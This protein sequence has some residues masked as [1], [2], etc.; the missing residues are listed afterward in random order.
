MSMIVFDELID[1]FRKLLR[2]YLH[3]MGVFFDFLCSNF[4]DLMELEKR[5]VLLSKENKKILEMQTKLFDLNPRDKQLSFLS[6]IYLTLLDFDDRKISDLIKKSKRLPYR[7][8]LDS[9]LKIKIPFV[10][11]SCVIYASFNTIDG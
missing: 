2:N 8:L 9:E 1:S 10:K 6:N 4:I 3:Q 11:D 5:S 7:M